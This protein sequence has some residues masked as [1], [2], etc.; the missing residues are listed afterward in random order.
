MMSDFGSH[1]LRGLMQNEKSL[2]RDNRNIED[3]DQFSRSLADREELI[4]ICNS[5]LSKR[6]HCRAGKQVSSSR[7]FN[8]KDSGSQLPQMINADQDITIPK[9]LYSSGSKV[10][11]NLVQK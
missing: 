10:L 9:C 6:S 11:Q 1:A 4:D 5:Q 3:F 2:H 7:Q 8:A